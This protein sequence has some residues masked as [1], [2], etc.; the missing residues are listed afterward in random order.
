MVFLINAI[1]CTQ[2]L[3]KD[4]LINHDCVS[5]LMLLNIMLYITLDYLM[6]F[7]ALS[8]D[9]CLYNAFSPLILSN[10]SVFMLCL[11]LL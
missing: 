4:K 3:K 8:I 6:L 7:A 10:A 5:I 2:K 9:V 1:M 11:G